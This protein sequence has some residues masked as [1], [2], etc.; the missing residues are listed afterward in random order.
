[1]SAFHLQSACLVQGKSSRLSNVGTTNKASFRAKVKIFAWLMSFL[2]Q[3]C[4]FDVAVVARALRNGVATGLGRFFFFLNLI[5]FLKNSQC[6][7]FLSLLPS[8]VILKWRNTRDGAVEPNDRPACFFLM[9]LV[10]PCSRWL[11]H[12][13]S[14]ILDPASFVSV[15]VILQLMI[16]S[17]SK[18]CGGV[19]FQDTSVLRATRLRKL[20]L[21]SRRSGKDVAR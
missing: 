4:G 21:E 6:T 15:R 12:N 8:L 7:P 11:V 9:C 18:K 5:F 3:I 2:W 19:C 13:W 20:M 1:M 16:K 14:G 10:L 17:R